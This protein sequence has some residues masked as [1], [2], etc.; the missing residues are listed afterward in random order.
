MKLRDILLLFKTLENS[1]YSDVEFKDLTIIELGEQELKLWKQD[2]YNIYI[3]NWISSNPRKWPVNPT[4]NRLGFYSKDFFNYYFKECISIDFDCHCNKSIKVNLE[5]DVFK[6]NID[7]QFDILTNIGTTENVGQII[8]TTPGS[9]IDEIVTI[10]K[11]PEKI[12]DH[13]RIFFA[14]TKY[15]IDER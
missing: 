9:K 5:N 10:K 6:Q 2:F 3:K 4:S 14:R 8:K 15:F 13:I 11:N 7:K 12:G 1:E